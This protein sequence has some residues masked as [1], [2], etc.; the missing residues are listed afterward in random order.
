[1][2][3]DLIEYEIAPEIASALN[4]SIRKLSKRTEAELVV[5]T[6]DAGRII[7]MDGKKP[8]QDFTAE[9]IASLISGVFGA[10]VEMGKILSLTDL[11]ILQYESKNMDVIIRAI[12]PRFLLGVLTKKGTSLG[13]AR[14][15][16]KES[17]EE[18]S[19]FLQNFRLVP[20]KVLRI[21][22]KSLEE[23]LNQILGGKK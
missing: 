8:P 1:M 16:I 3:L 22:P 17:T 12:P 10:A 13:T 14:L 11:E 5:L 2:E 23:R 6:D 7:A 21:D 9:F 4:M 19:K 20:T 18:L 15:F